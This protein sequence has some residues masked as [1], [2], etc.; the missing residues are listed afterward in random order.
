MTTANVQTRLKRAMLAGS[1]TVADLST[2]FARP[3]AT[4]RGWLQGYEPWGPH[5]EESRRLLALLEQ[6]IKRRR[7][8]P[9]PVQMSPIERRNH[10]RQVRHDLDGGFFKA[11]AAK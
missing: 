4:V 7:G 11:R 8:F 6:A 9:V 3:Y 5:G 10:V 1:L 2:W